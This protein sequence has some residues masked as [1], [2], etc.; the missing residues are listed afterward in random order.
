MPSAGKVNGLQ[1][2][3]P[4]LVPFKGSGKVRGLLTGD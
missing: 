1:H 2:A 3:A 4:D